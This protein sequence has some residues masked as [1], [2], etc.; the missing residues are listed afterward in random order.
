M[1]CRHYW[2]TKTQTD[3]ESQTVKTKRQ[4]EGTDIQKTDSDIS[5]VWSALCHPL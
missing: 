3:T 2:Q 5:S 1:I 4:T